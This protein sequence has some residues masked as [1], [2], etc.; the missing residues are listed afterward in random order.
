MKDA[1]TILNFLNAIGSSIILTLAII[2]YI[3]VRKSFKI[4][5]KE[6]NEL[7]EQREKE[8]TWKH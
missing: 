8:K 3:K 2:M 1:T 5:R 6:I 4:Q 7:R